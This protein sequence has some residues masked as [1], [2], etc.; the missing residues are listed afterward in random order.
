MAGKPWPRDFRRR[1]FGSGLIAGRAAGG[2]FSLDKVR[3]VVLQAR[4]LGSRSAG[5]ET[6]VR[7]GFFRRLGWTERNVRRD[8]EILREVV[9]RIIEVAEPEQVILFGSAARGQLRPDSD[10]DLLVIKSDVEDTRALTRY[11]HAHLF[12]IR[13]PIDIIVATP[14]EVEASQR[15]MLGQIYAQGRRIY[16]RPQMQRYQPRW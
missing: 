12:D 2:Q 16:P 15:K 13:M 9:R 5:K 4:L 11:I 1:I 7:R 8:I 3:R 14:E 6:Q 10:F